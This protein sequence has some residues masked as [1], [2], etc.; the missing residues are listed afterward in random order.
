MLQNHKTGV[1]LNKVREGILKE[2][3][4]EHRG[5][6]LTEGRRKSTRGKGD[7]TYGERVQCLQGFVHNQRGLTILSH[8]KFKNSGAFPGSGRSLTLTQV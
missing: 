4:I 7:S 6:A 2:V 3:M 1:L 5:E 8:S